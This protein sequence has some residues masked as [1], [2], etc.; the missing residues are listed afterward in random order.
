VQNPRYYLVG[1]S[2]P[3]SF[4]RCAGNQYSSACLKLITLPFR[5]HWEANPPRPEEKERA[6]KKKASKT[7][8][9]CQACEQNAWA[10]PGAMLEA[11]A[12]TPAKGCRRS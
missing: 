5:L 4:Q 6:E 2:A 7:K 11:S 9:T 10:K 3:N 12:K 8:Y 1:E